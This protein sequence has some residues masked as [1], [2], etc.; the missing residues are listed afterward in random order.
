MQRLQPLIAPWMVSPSSSDILVQYQETGACVVEFHATISPSQQP[1]EGLDPEAV[2]V[3]VRFHD[4][5]SLSLAPPHNEE[6]VIDRAIYDWHE[7]LSLTDFPSLEE[8][9][10]RFHASWSQKGTC[11]D[12][13]FYNVLDSLLI[14]GSL[15][16]LQLSHYLILGHDTSVQV[17]ARDIEWTWAR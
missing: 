11:P 9:L 6:S 13:R 8:Y 17:I 3:R 5:Y 14:P 16:L 7:V 1:P 10:R 15:A 2:R 4:V 12:P